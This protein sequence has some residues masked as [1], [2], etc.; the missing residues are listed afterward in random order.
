[1]KYLCV[2]KIASHG[3]E[4]ISK[5]QHDECFLHLS[6]KSLSIILI[7][8]VL[9]IAATIWACSR[10]SVIHI[11]FCLILVTVFAQG[12]RLNVALFRPEDALPRHS[13]RT[14]VLAA[15]RLPCLGVELLNLSGLCSSFNQ[16]ECGQCLLYWLSTLKSRLNLK[17]N[18]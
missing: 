9:I 17:G 14:Q 15:D 1:M 13:L 6:T 18:F 10:H 2:R 4:E 12:K 16:R 5:S 3:K 11:L 8:S 7:K